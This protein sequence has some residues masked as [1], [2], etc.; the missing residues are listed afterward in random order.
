M[1]RQDET[2]KKNKNVIN[3]KERLNTKGKKV[4]LTAAVSTTPF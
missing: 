3:V 1:K 4:K 2:N